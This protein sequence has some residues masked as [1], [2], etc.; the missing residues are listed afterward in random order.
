QFWFYLYPTGNPYVATAADLR[1]ALARLRFE[2]D[3]QHRDPALEQMVFVGHSMGG[4]ISKLLT[5]DSGN[6]FWGL[7]SGQ[8]FEKVKA[9]PETRTELQSIFFFEQQPCIKRVVFLG[10]PHHGSNLSPSP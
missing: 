2:L 8:P 1:Q 3:P 4:L 10:T 7:V 5:Q 6:D 9:T